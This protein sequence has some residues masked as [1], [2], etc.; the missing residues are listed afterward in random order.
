MSYNNIMSEIRKIDMNV[1]CSEDVMTKINDN[2]RIV[3]PAEFRRQMGLK[4]G[5]AVIMSLEGGILRIESQ[6]AKIRK[7]Q[8]EFKQFASS[9]SRDSGDLVAERLEEARR[10]MEEWLG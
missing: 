1:I 2:G 10:E 5:D 9:A 8:A 3:I 7:I 4:P 6:R